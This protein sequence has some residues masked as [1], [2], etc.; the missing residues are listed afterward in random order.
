MNRPRSWVPLW[1]CEPPCHATT[2]IVQT[3]ADV[4]EGPSSAAFCNSPEFNDPP[5]LSFTA[6][7]SVIETLPAD[8]IS[9][10]MYLKIVVAEQTP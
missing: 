4:G 9:A 10:S 5:Y 2:D 6:G 7:W 1:R 8:R 3:G